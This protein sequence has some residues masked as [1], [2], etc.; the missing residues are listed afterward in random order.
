MGD[1]SIASSSTPSKQT[2]ILQGALQVFLQNGYEGASMDRIAAAAGVSKITIYKHF[3]DKEGLF[4]ALIEQ[5]AAE[6]FNTVFGSLSW[7]EDPTVMLRQVATKLLDTL[8]ID[9]EYIAFLR[10]II[11]ES[12]RFPTLAQ[13]FVNALP[14]KA[15]TR[16]CQ[17]FNA[18]PDMQFKNPDAIARIFTGA[19]ISYVMTQKILH[20]QT[21]MPMNQEVL[22]DSLIDMIVVYGTRHPG[23]EKLSAG[24]HP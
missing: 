22:I 18:H 23:T 21:M 11:G 7:D 24:L 19:L 17:Y 13:L 12:G 16:L 15:W 10:L 9:E 20:G 4:T 6:R 2:Q 3:K 5:V 8:A 1:H 14:Q